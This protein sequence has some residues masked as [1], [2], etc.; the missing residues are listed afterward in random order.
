MQRRPSTVQRAQGWRPGMPALIG[1]GV[2][3]HVACCPSSHV[4]GTVIPLAFF[5]N[6]GLQGEHRCWFVG[7]ACR[8]GRALCCVL[9]AVYCPVLSVLDP[10]SGSSRPLSPCSTQCILPFPCLEA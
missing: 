9:C 10:R 5:L 1:A 2:C 6:S 3:P 8:P 7:E 4:A